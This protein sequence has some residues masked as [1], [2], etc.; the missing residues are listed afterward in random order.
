LKI[1]YQHV[2][3]LP[4]KIVWKYIKDEKVLGNAIPNCKS[5][6]QNKNGLYQAQIDI[7]MGPIKDVFSLEVNLAR[8]KAPSYYHL[9]LKGKGNLG[10]FTGKGDVFL[11]DYQGGTKLII[12]ADVEITGT[13][14][15]AAQRVLNSGSYQGIEKFFQSLETEIKRNL[16]LIRKGQKKL[17]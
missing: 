12:N 10:D 5:I 7:K 8:E 13:L 2:L 3:G 6:F 4:R 14:A 1:E 15:G 9:L 11:S 17:K 16:Y